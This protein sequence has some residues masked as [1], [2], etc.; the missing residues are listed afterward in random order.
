MRAL[1]IIWKRTRMERVVTSRTRPRTQ[2]CRLRVG[3]PIA[4]LL[5]RSLA[6]L[7]HAGAAGELLLLRGLHRGV[8]P[9]HVDPARGQPER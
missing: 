2:D 3:V 9:P 6:G 8:L 4:C 5:A 1:L 7:A